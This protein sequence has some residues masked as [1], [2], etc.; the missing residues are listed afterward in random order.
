MELE[1][2]KIELARPISLTQ[3]QEA[4]EAY[5]EERSKVKFSDALSAAFAED[6]AMSW[7]YNGLED[8][9]PDENFLLDD[10][11]YAELTKDIP[12]E[13]HDFLE[14]AVSRPHAEK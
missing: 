12:L 7:I 4:L 8:H 13:Y 14:D 10:D 2:E 11:S 6:N 5:E 3:E 1:A 9:E